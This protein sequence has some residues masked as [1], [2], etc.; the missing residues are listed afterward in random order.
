MDIIFIPIIIITILIHN[1]SNEASGHDTWRSG[2]PLNVL[3][4]YA[5][6]V[7]IKIKEKQTIKKKNRENMNS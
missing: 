2:T 1:S 5:A 3:C 6:I 4:L 7:A